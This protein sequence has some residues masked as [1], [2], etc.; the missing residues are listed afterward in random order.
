MHKDGMI[1]CKFQPVELYTNGFFEAR[2]KERYGVIDKN[3]NVIIPL[4]YDGIWGFKN[5]FFK[6]RLCKEMFW[7]N[8]D[9]IKI[10][11]NIINKI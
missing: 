10:K 11:I 4:I 8:Q 3:R 5:G 1:K 2:I 9:G 6:V 7:V